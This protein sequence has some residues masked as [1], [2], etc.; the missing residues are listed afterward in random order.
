MK[1]PKA[2]SSAD[3]NNYDKMLKMMKKIANL[4][5]IQKKID[6]NYR[7]VFLNL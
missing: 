6:L 4:E 5:Y 2:M 3:K 1:K 7:S